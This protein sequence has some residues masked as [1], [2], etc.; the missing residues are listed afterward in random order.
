MIVA[1]LFKA[2]TFF[3]I[4][5]NGLL[6]QWNGV[7]GAVLNDFHIRTVPVARPHCYHTSVG[8]PEESVPLARNRRLWR[9][10]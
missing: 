8:R 5:L 1:R 10:R 7:L 2:T 9:Y 4:Q 3:R 6:K